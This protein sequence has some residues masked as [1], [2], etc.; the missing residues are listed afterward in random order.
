V[1][2]VPAAPAGP[3]GPGTLA[4]PL[5][6]HTLE[7]SN[8]WGSAGWLIDVRSGK[9]LNHAT[10]FPLA[11]QQQTPYPARVLLPFQLG[12]LPSGSCFTSEQQRYNAYM[13]ITYAV[14][15]GLAFYNIG[16]DKPSVDDQAYP[17]LR[18]T[19]GRWYVFNGVWRS[20]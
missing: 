13:S 3:V 6:T 4:S 10:Y 9:P 19:D 16:P 15:N 11:P 14:L 7:Q 18:T 20:P 12:T 2:L 17:W 8:G 1:P 5:G